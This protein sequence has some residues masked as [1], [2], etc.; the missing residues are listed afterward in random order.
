MCK[1]TK[2]PP[3]RPQIE[4]AILRNFSGF[5]KINT[6]QYF[7][8]EIQYSSSP[9]EKTHYEWC[10]KWLKNEFKQLKKVKNAFYELYKEKHLRKLTEDFAKTPEC[11]KPDSEQQFERYQKRQFGKCLEKND[12]EDGEINTTF[13]AEYHE[14]FEK[15]FKTEV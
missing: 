12:F 10:R 11:Q 15:R 14:Y 8:A 2:Q 4:H 3:N 13:E 1:I 6:L 9:D 5:D 7:D